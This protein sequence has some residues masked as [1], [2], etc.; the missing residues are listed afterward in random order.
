[1]TIL[2]LF[3]DL[4]FGKSS[5]FCCNSYGHVIFAILFYE[6]QAEYLKKTFTKEKKC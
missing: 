3:K 4:K 2:L 1:M 5:L 6:F